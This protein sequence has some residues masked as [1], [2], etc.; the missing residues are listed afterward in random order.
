MSDEKALCLK[1]HYSLF[2]A[3]QRGMADEVSE[4][5]RRRSTKTINLSWM[6]RHCIMTYFG[7]RPKEELVRWVA[8]FCTKHGLVSDVLRVWEE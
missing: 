4:M 3:L 1:L 7:M 6:I 8:Q 2:E 5:L